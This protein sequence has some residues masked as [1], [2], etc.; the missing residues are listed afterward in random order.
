M[1]IIFDT[2]TVPDKGKIEINVSRSFEIKIT[3]KEAQ[4]LVDRW[5]LDEVS[6]LIGADLPSLVIGERVVWRVPAWISFPHTGRLGQ[7]GT[8][9]VD[10]ETG[11]M[12][13]LPKC[14]T[15]IEQNLEKLEP[16]VPP[17]KPKHLSPDSEYLVKN[18]LPTPNVTPPEKEQPTL[19][20][21]PFLEVN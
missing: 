2:Y 12:S 17:Y 3:A 7:V 4:R 5:L 18:M 6:Y 9:D 11:Q 19:V 21:T 15:A 8:V 13:D 10:V 1:T 14:K 20:V 16:H